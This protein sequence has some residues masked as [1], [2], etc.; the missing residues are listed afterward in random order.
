[1]SY[2][3]AEE[4]AADPSLKWRRINAANVILSGK[5]DRS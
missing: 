1:M 4:I 2:F 3:S 5:A